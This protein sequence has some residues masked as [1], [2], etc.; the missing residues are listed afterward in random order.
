MEGQGNNWTLYFVYTKSIMGL[1]GFPYFER[2]EGKWS[3][4]ILNNSPEYHYEWGYGN[5]IF[6]NGKFG[7][8]VLN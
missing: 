7:N 3:T 1:M 8:G 4:K 2:R 5:A 6:N